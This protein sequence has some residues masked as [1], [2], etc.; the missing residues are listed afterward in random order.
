MNFKPEDIFENSDDLTVD[1]KERLDILNNNLEKA[2]VLS[3]FM[4]CQKMF[5]RVEGF[6]LDHGYQENE[7][8]FVFESE[9]IS[10]EEYSELLTDLV[11]IVFDRWE[12]E[13]N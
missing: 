4:D 5:D 12:K 10:S 1:Q 13:S 6:I 11:N 9:N 8:E 3:F 7:D 2:R